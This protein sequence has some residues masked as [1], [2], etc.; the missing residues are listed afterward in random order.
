MIFVILKIIGLL[1]NLILY[2]ASAF[3]ILYPLIIKKDYKDDFE[4]KKFIHI[5]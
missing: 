2:G 1:F 3:L 5:F 4:Q